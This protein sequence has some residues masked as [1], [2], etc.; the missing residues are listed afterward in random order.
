MTKR[1]RKK[2]D[3]NK[4]PKRKVGL[5]PIVVVV[6]IGVIIAAGVIIELDPFAPEAPKEGPPEEVIPQ[7]NEEPEQE[8]ARQVIL[9]TN[10]G[11]IEMEL[12]HDKA[13]RTVENFLK[14]AG[15]GFYDGTRFHRV[16]EGFMIQ[17]GCPYSADVAM[18][19][20]WGTGGPG[21]TFDCE[22]HDENFNVRGTIAM[23]NAGPNTNGSQFFINVAN[24]DWLNAGHTVFGRVVAGMDVVDRIS[25]V[26]TDPRDVPL[27]AVILQSV[28]V[29]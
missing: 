11:E 15:E 1:K 22:I 13:P 17:G 21:Y 7:P 23:A 8:V 10:V 14:L 2:R 24:N 20:R 26:E 6:L 29:R 16:I 25:T 3:S 12:F 28:I 19:D 5:F 4:T 9:E 18:K 27:E